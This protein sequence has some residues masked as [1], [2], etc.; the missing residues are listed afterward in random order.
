MDYSKM[1][2]KKQLDDLQSVGFTLIR[3]AHLEDLSKSHVITMGLLAKY[4]PEMSQEDYD[5]LQYAASLI[6]QFL[7]DGDSI[8]LEKE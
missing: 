2:T 3:I 1:I 8:M 7:R 5:K 6:K 4:A